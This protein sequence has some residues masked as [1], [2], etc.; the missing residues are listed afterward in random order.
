MNYSDKYKLIW[1]APMRTG[2]RSLYAIL[3]GYLDFYSSSNRKDIHD[4]SLPNSKVD[5]DKNKENYNV[6]LSVRNPY[7]RMVSLYNL[8][9]LHKKNID[10]P[11]DK[12]IKETI[13]YKKIGYQYD[14]HIEFKNKYPDYIIH[15]ESMENDIKQIPGVLDNLLL[16]DNDI[17]HNLIKNN[18][19]TDRTIA[20]KTDD[21]WKS[22]YNQE[23]I[24]IVS[25]EL[26]E[27]FI[28]FGYDKNF[29]L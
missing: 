5:E 24:D 1:Y 19:T 23:L 10:Y 15:L 18:Y 22:Y 11:F 29:I 14:Y 28:M 6:I 8:Y 3:F 27:Q 25:T 17:K 4:H 7:S 20:D 16:M 9:R 12:F 21:Y 26:H 13:L 2:T